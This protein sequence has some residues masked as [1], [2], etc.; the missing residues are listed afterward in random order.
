MNTA[1]KVNLLSSHS[2]N[3]VSCGKKNQNQTK[4]NQ[5][6]LLGFVLSAIPIIDGWL[7]YDSSLL[8]YKV[9]GLQTVNGN[10]DFGKQGKTQFKAF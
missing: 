4:P 7:H 3:R 10:M 8:I 1:I 2:F 5:T 6:Q 9:K